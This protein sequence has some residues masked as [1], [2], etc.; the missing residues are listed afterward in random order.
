MISMRLSKVLL[1]AVVLMLSP[2]N[3]L[4]QKSTGLKRPISLDKINGGDLFAL[5]GAGAVLRLKVGQQGAVPGSSFKLPAFASPSDLVSA[6][7]FGQDVLLV[8]TNNQKSGFL[9]QYSLEGALQNTWAL[10]K[11]VVGVDVDYNSHIVYLAAYDTP[12]IY[13]ITLQPGSSQTKQANSPPEFVGSVLGAAHLGPLIVDLSRGCLYLGDL[14][15]GQIFQFD[16]KTHN[17]RVIASNLSSP[18]ALLLSAD[19]T[20]LYIADSSR[21]RIY[22]LDLRRPKAVPRIFSEAPQFRSPSGL[23]K[24]EGGQVVVAD[25]QAGMIF[26]L[27]PT[28]TVQSVSTL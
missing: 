24:L 17:S 18:H 11:L 16:L 6:K 27:S 28:G 12:E 9:S 1:I 25:P 26:I 5:D 7:L 3:I 22:V 14:D 15:A 21:R 2:H 23:A 10:H 20:L 4:G 13:K 19:S 8:T